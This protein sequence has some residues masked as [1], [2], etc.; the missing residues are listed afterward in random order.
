MLNL[1]I[2][3]KEFNSI[4]FREKR[5]G[6]FKVILPYFYEDG[7]MY[8]VFIEEHG[9]KIRI[10]D[11]GLTIMKLSYNFEFDT[12]RKA[13]ILQN[14]V[15]Q[16]RCFIER[17]C[18]YLDVTPTQ[19]NCGIYQ[20]VQTI[21]KVS[22]M[23]IISRESIKSYFYDYL[24][25]FVMERFK[26]YNITANTAPMNNELIV[27]YVIPTSNQKPIYLFGVNDDTKASKVVIACL[28]FINNKIPY[29]SLVIHEDSSNLSKFNQKQLMN[30]ADKQY[31]SLEDFKKNA[32]E[33]AARFLA[34]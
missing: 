22:T 6:I 12:P 5:P 33:F 20:F 28:H 19:F 18:I 30:T 14:I 4:D 10:S 29:Q 2:L 23:E 16:N 25:T 13:E 21:S 3:K 9:S 24:N 26:K 1:D 8:D 17:G 11:Y 15:T 7:D 27:D 31:A 34:S 32:D